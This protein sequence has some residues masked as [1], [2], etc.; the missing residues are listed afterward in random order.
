[1]K[2][3]RLEPKW[4]TREGQ[5]RWPC[6]T[7]RIWNRAGTEAELFN[8]HGVWV[9]GNIP[10]AL[11]CLW[12]LWIL[13]IVCFLRL[14]ASVDANAAGVS[15]EADSQA[16]PAVNVRVVALCTELYLCIELFFCF[17]FPSSLFSWIPE[18]QLWGRPAPASVCCRC[19]SLSLHH[20]SFPVVVVFRLLSSVLFSRRWLILVIFLSLPNSD[21][22]SL[23]VIYRTAPNSSLLEAMF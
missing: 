22:L 5:W 4:R 1:M 7:W 19:D 12:R 6:C 14:K 23:T 13:F 9:L 2:G 17:Y 18:L 20:R 3:G 8:P 16:H 10:A 15:P 11:W 21:C